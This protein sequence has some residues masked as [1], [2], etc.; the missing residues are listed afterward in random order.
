MKKLIKFM[1]MAIVFE[2]LA[3][4]IVSFV[5]NSGVYPSGADTMC[6]I[7]KGDL[8]YHSILKGNIYPL[9]DELWY[10]GV[11]MLRYWAPLPVYFLAMCQALAGGNPFDGYLLFVGVVFFLGAMVWAFIGEKKGHFLFGS[12]IGI[13]WFFMPNNM[14]ALFLEGN[15]PRALCMI[16]LPLFVYDVSEYLLHEKWKHLFGVIGWFFLMVFCHSGYAGMIAIGTLI[17]LIIYGIMSQKYIKCIHIVVCMVVAFVTTGLWLVPSLTGGITSTDSSEVMASFFQSGFLSLN[18]M[19]RITE[20][21]IYFYFG[22]A[23][24]L[25]ALF[26]MLF[27]KKEL[28]PG[29]LTAIIIYFSTTNTAYPAL[30]ILPGSQYLWML[31][32][33]SIA[34][35][36]IL[37]SFLNWS[38]L[39]KS[40]KVLFIALLVLDAIPSLSLMSGK[41]NSVPV[42]TRFDD[43]QKWALID[44]AKQLSEQRIALLDGSTLEA[45]GA[46]LVS[47]YNGL[48]AATYGAGWQSANT[49]TNISQLDRALIGGNYRY[50]FDRCMELGNDVVLVKMSLIDQ[51]TAPIYEMDEAAA[52]VGYSVVD[53]NI[54]YRLYHLD[55]SGHWGTVSKF[56]SI[57]IGRGASMMSLGFPSIEETTSTNLN[58]YTFEELSQYKTVYLNGF[59]YTDK[60][61]AEELVLKL[62]EAGV[63]VIIMADGIPE[64]RNMQGQE[65]LGVRCYP[66]VFSNGYPEL[67]TKDGILNPDLFPDGFTKWKTVYMQGL[68][69]VWGRIMED[70]L[71]LDFYGTAHNENLVFIGLNLTYHYGLTQ[72]KSI[73]NL[74]GKVMDIEE[75][76]LPE[77][78]IVPYDVTY[79]KNS[80]TITTDANQVNTGLAF[81]DIFQSKANITGK[82]H[83]LY[84]DA[85][86][87]EITMDYP[88]FWPGLLVTLLGILLVT[89]TLVMT[90]VDRN[91]M[92]PWMRDKSEDL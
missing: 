19:V 29:F 24:F 37:Y 42:E 79:G 8:L 15:L 62:S 81:H 65:F 17:F 4:A 6:H 1:G 64:D 66:I 76:A 86:T 41:M 45:T 51:R 63:R 55:V 23:S 3:M 33:I 13:L 89:V 52:L 68:D 31:R 49:G 26:G 40:L 53:S 28:I 56:D 73:G 82:N 87:T 69:D 36:F 21:H 67:E 77:R 39:R 46:F 58:D 11:E 60:I 75:A 16:M 72:D 34:L 32:F 9:Y 48:S 83:L 7:Y 10:N 70:D 88:M 38:S 59:T 35:C 71:L 5:Y 20:G 50:L 2:I 14:Y 54:D 27:G 25:L 43:A 74:L 12:F 90:R 18:P 44:K 47:D 92:V 57:G 80:I 30:K 22:L 84:V 85:G 78:K 61:M 91:H